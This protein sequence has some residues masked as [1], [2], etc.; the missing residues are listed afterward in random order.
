MGDAA[1][2]GFVIGHDVIAFTQA[3]GGGA[4]ALLA[5]IDVTIG[6]AHDQQVDRSGHFG[7][8]RAFMRQFG[9]D[10][11]RA[12]VREQAQFL[13]QAQ[14]RLLRTQMPLQ[15][16]AVGITDRAEQDGVGALGDV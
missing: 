12:Q 13:A 3:I 8:Q 9:E 6:L 4:H 14:D 16:V 7:L 2:L 5:E 15:R 1:H 10:L 11:G